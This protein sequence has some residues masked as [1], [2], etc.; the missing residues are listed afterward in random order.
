MASPTDNLDHYYRAGKAYI[1]ASKDGNKSSVCAIARGSPEWAAWLGWFDEANIRL[2]WS[3]RHEDMPTVPCQFP[4]W[5]KSFYN[6][7]PRLP[8][9]PRRRDREI[10]FQIPAAERERVR[11]KFQLLRDTFTIRGIHPDEGA[12]RPPTPNQA[13]EI[14][15]AEERLAQAKDAGWDGVSF[16]DALRHRLSGEP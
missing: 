13:A 9:R 15:A 14:R 6:T 1:A 10:E 2:P 5:F 11:Q 4:D 12:R 7:H 16:S 8:P 3:F